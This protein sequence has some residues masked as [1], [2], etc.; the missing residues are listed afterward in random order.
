MLNLLQPASQARY[1]V[2]ISNFHSWLKEH[3]VAWDQLTEEDQD[4]TVAGYILDLRDDGILAPQVARDLLSALQKLNARR[5][6][7]VAWK[8]VVGWAVDR[9]AQQALP[10]PRL[11]ALALTVL[12]TVAG[13]TGAG[14]GVLLCWCGLL[15]I[16]E[17]LK[18]TIGDVRLTEAEVVLYLGVTKRGT[19]EKVVLNDPG[20]MAF[21][22]R[23]LAQRA[24]ALHE[25][26]VVMS[27][28]GFSLWFRRGLRSLGLTDA[29]RSHSMRRGGATAMYLAG[30]PLSAVMQ[31]GRW[32]SETSC[33]LYIRPAEVILLRSE[34]SWSPAVRSRLELLA[35]IGPGAFTLMDGRAKA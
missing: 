1:N 5:R 6:L 16:G 12:L 26:L 22:D 3:F 25:R 33:R 2:A 18:L 13:P 30:H 15:R 19:S 10:L 14:L 35:A 7:V 34:R 31:Y 8:V 28:T 9:P 32:A 29:Y 20:V 4:F 24:G 11:A 23:Y 21:V 27:Y 17:V